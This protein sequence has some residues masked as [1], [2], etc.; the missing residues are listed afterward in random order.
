MKD[1]NPA[2]IPRLAQRLLEWICPDYLLEGIIGDLEEQYNAA[3]RE[4][5]PPKARLRLYWNVLRLV[6]PAMILRNRVLFRV[7]HPA[8]VRSHFTVAS[9]SLRKSPFYSLVN[10]SGLSFSMMFIVLS[11]LFIEKER[12]YDTFHPDRH[13]IYR[14]AVS[15]TRDSGERISQSAITAVPVGPMLKSEV[16]QISHASR[17][18]STAVKLMFENEPYSELA[19]FVDSDF[20]RMFGFPVTD[21]AQ[22]PG[23]EGQE[24]V[25]SLE[26]SLQYFGKSN[27]VGEVM[28]FSIQDSLVSFRIVSVLDSKTNASSLAL[29]FILPMSAYQRAVSD[30][31]MDSFR[32]GILENYVLLQEGADREEVARLA[33][34]ALANH[35]LE[36]T[37]SQVILQP[38]TEIHLETEI[39]GNASFTDPSR[40]YIMA[41]LVFLVFLVSVINF[42]TL[43]TGQALDRL[44]EI[45]LR[46]S[47]G[48]HRTSLRFQLFFE[49]CIL[50]LLAAALGTALAHLLTPYFGALLE[51]QLPFEP[52]WTVLLIILFTSGLTALLAGGLQSG[53]L[54]NYSVIRAIR[55]KVVPRSSSGL[56]NQSLM[57]AQFMI[58]TILIVGTLIVREQLEFIRTKDL[59]FEKEGLIQVTM[60]ST[61]DVVAAHA[62]ADRFITQAQSSTR[63]SAVASSMNN[64]NE[65]WTVLTFRQENEREEKIYYNLV[66]HR[67]LETMGIRLAEGQFFNELG[68]SATDIVVN[69]ALVRHFGWES[70]IGQEIPGIDFSTSYRVIGVVEDFHFSSLK[71]RVAPLILTQDEASLM[72]GVRGL[73]TYIWPPNKYQLYVRFTTADLPAVVEDLETIWEATSSAAPLT[74]QFVDDLVAQQYE[75]ERRWNDVINASSVFAIFI[76]WM[77][78]LGFTRLSVTRRTKEIGI[79]KTLGSTSWRIITLLSS[80]LSLQVAFAVILA[81]P[82]SW[83]LANRWLSTFSYHIDPGPVVYVTGGCFVLGLVVL[84]TGVQALA[85]SRMKPTD[86]LRYE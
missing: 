82:I 61:D 60:G 72:D 66:D 43:S 41:G 54:I 85:A 20:M 38:L 3:I 26:K 75:E 70:A 4:S 25:I 76:A 74:Y 71:E 62:L 55:E 83:L 14:V 30:E 77:G 79:R 50:T 24:M 84:S 45:G 2:P 37:R 80:R 36:G 29:G 7:I 63:I 67:Y 42:I 81:F 69:E 47:L 8:L 21:G 49:A 73:V 78:L 46:K 86:S 31:A 51:V 53:I 13:Q 56:L 6:H 15:T 28:H 58:S 40:L 12:S 34:N 10:I 59:G 57:I 16:P 11:T 68:N 35:D 1:L 27:S 65:P 44:K 48:A 5:G 19:Y 9:R 17:Y 64:S 39:T 33:S 23:F 32:Y 52:S 18:A 22:H